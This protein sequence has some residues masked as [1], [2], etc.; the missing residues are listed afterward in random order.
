MSKRNDGDT[1]PIAPS[2]HQNVGKHAQRPDG[3]NSQS[4]AN[5]CPPAEA[6]RDAERKTYWT[7]DKYG[8]MLIVDGERRARVDGSKVVIFTHGESKPRRLTAPDSKVP[9]DIAERLAG[10]PRVERFEDRGLRLFITSPRPMHERAA[11]AFSQKVSTERELR[12]YLSQA[13]KLLNDKATE[14]GLAV[15]GSGARDQIGR[16][17]RT[18]QVTGNK[19]APATL[20]HIQSAIENLHQTKDDPLAPYQLSALIECQKA[21]SLIELDPELPRV[22]DL[23][24]EAHLRPSRSQ[25]SGPGWE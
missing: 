5:D 25:R 19:W 1:A 10:I 24:P 13:W 14:D 22:A 3:A 12:H 8:W 4:P 15:N 6:S 11:A 9:F 23:E 7:S 17:I 20:E 21:L 2:L 16:A 18:L